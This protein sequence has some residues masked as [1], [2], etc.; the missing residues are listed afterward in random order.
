[1][2]IGESPLNTNI[3]LELIKIVESG[4]YELPIIISKEYFSFLNAI[5]QD[6][7]NAEEISRDSFLKKNVGEFIKFYPDKISNYLITGPIFIIANNNQNINILW[8]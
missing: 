1:M 8:Y 7:L 6:N 5:L 2:F 4:L 3:L